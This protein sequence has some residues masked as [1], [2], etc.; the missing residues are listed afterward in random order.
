MWQYEN[1]LLKQSVQYLVNLGL[2][3]KQLFQYD[4]LG[5]KQIVATELL[6]DF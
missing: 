1:N 3:L 5:N 4:I 2:K 6:L